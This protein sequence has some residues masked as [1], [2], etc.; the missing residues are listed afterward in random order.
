MD[1][2]QSAT[3]FHL[4]RPVKGRERRKIMIE[5]SIVQRVNKIDIYIR[6]V[7]ILRTKH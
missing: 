4:L 5:P 6:N 2:F 3:Y 1:E 7:V